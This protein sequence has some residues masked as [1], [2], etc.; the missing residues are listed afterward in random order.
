MRAL[1]RAPGQEGF[2]DAVFQRMEAHYRKPSLTGYQS[3]IDLPAV[4]RL[5]PAFAPELAVTLAELELN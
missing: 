2:H 3:L 1:A 4:Q 5:T